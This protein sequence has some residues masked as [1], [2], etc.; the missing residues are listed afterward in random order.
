MP[1]GGIRPDTFSDIYDP[2]LSEYHLSGRS[3]RLSQSPSQLFDM[4]WAET[5]REAIAQVAYHKPA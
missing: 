1:G 3:A 5:S 2:N 4:D